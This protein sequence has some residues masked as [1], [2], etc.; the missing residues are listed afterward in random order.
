LFNNIN[1]AQIFKKKPIK[2]QEQRNTTR[3]L[4]N[5]NRNT[6]G[7]FSSVDCNKFYQQN[8]SSLYSSVNTDGTIFLVYTE[9]ITVGKEGIKKNTMMVLNIFGKIHL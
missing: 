9:R 6:N 4:I 3:K 1:E 5:I 8:I 2:I 7:M